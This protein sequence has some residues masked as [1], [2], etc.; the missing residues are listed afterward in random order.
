[1]ADFWFTNKNSETSY[2]YKGGRKL[3]KIDFPFP[4]LDRQEIRL[5][6][7]FR[8]TESAPS[9]LGIDAIYSFP[10]HRDV[11][12]MI[13]SRTH[14]VPQMD[15]D[16]TSYPNGIVQFNSAALNRIMPD[17]IILRLSK[18]VLKHMHQDE[19]GAVIVEAGHLKSGVYGLNAQRQIV[20][21]KDLVL[22]T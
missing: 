16:R 9:K 4:S 5:T 18:L 6:E 14:Y 12:C 2:P 1:M 17:D 10:N 7:C 3:T 8:Q 11:G 15:K 22:V 19:I 13:D 21:F 20:P